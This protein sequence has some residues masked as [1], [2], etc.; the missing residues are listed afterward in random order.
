MRNSFVKWM[1][2]NFIPLILCAVVY[3]IISSRINPAETMHE[4][5]GRIANFVLPGIGMYIISQLVID[6]WGK[7]S[8]LLVAPTTLFFYIY[9]FILIVNRK[10]Q[11]DLSL[12]FLFT[13][14]VGGGL[15]YGLLI[16]GVKFRNAPS[17]FKSWQ[18]F[19][20]FLAT[21][22]IGSIIGYGAL[23]ITDDFIRHISIEFEQWP[24]FIFGIPVIFMAQLELINREIRHPY[25]SQGIDDPATT[26]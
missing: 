25:N 4:L 13:L 14:T 15:L 18:L 9:V 20:G 3:I 8:V 17:V 12:D 6:A 24:F 7:E 22:G 10:D 1:V 2:Y 11:L 26:E 23:R 16:A 5:A 21:I 19:Q